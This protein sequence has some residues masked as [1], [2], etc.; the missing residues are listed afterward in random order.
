MSWVH[1]SQFLGVQ[2]TRRLCKILHILRSAE[3]VI[4][5][6]VVCLLVWISVGA[7]EIENSVF[8]ETAIQIEATFAIPAFT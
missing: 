7:S 2:N 8:V 3:E 1:K 6:V 5:Y 4:F